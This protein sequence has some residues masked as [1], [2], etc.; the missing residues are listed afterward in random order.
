MSDAPS[1]GEEGG[2][3]ESG[4]DREKVEKDLSEL[5][6][7]LNARRKIVERDEGVERAKEEVVACLKVNDRRPL[8]C[9]E[10]VER[11]KAEVGRLERS[12]VDRNAA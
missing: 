7:K 11:F 3:G 4:L 1:Q 10:Q 2:K 12:F 9:W 8:D 6:K 5:R